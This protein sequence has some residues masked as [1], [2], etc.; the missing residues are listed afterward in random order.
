MLGYPSLTS[1]L[2]WSAAAVTALI[3]APLL[4][5][6][7]WR[8]SPQL[9]RSL[10]WHLVGSAFLVF[11]LIWGTFGSVL[12]WDEVYSAI[13]PAWFRWLLPLIYGS[14]FGAVALG[15]WRLSLFA[16]SRQVVWFC[17]LGGLVSLVGHSIGASRGLMQVP[18][19]AGTSIASAFTFG[20][21]EF[22][23]YFCIIVGLAVIVRRLL[24][25][26]G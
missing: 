17:L 13:F 11:A 23:F 3:D 12:Y 18:L 4:A 1:S 19:L 24:F 22:I 15:F 5:L 20:I 7:A 8:I 6:L 2:M 14:L 21:F 26:S 25:R 9:F 10:K 16:A